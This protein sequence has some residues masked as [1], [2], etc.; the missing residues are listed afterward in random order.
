VIADLA[1]P[2]SPSTVGTLASDGGVKALRLPAD[3][4]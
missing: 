4:S 2:L 3:R 1:S